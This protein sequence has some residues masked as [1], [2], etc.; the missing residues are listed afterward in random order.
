MATNKEI[1]QRLDCIESN[2]ANG[3]I[4]EIHGTVNEIKQI[5]LDP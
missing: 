1:L 3:Q 2:V 4:D 5:L